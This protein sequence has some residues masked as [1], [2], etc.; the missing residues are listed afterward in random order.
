MLAT[1]FPSKSDSRQWQR[2]IQVAAAFLYQHYTCPD[3]FQN[4]CSVSYHLQP[5]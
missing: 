3:F 2:Q 5:P 4:E 1:G